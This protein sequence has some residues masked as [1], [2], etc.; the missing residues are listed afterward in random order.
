MRNYLV[1][2]EF[3]KIFRQLEVSLLFQPVIYTFM[4]F[5]HL[6]VLYI[7]YWVDKR[8]YYLF[9]SSSYFIIFGIIYSCIPLMFHY[10]LKMKDNILFVFTL[11]TL[12]LLIIST[13]IG[14]ISAT[15]L[16]LNNKYNDKFITECPFSFRENDYINLLNKLPIHRIYSF[17]N[18]A[19][20]INNQDTNNPN[21]Y[22]C[23]YYKT[24]I[25]QGIDCKSYMKEE[26]A[27]YKINS[28]AYYTFLKICDSDESYFICDLKKNPYYNLYY[29]YECPYPIYS[30]VTTI[31]G[32]ILILFD[33]FMNV[34]VWVGEYLSYCKYKETMLRL[35]SEENK[36]NK[37]TMETSKPAEEDPGSF[38]KNSTEYIFYDGNDS[39]KK[40]NIITLEKNADNG[41]IKNIK[42]EDEKDNNL[43]NKKL[44]N[45]K[46]SRTNSENKNDKNDEK[47][48]S[49][50]DKIIKFNSIGE[51]SSISPINIDDKGIFNS[52]NK[53]NVFSKNK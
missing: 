42:N 8:Y 29:D 25:Q 4:I 1:S 23:N 32:I 43:N 30:I 26:F 40:S 22:I 19:R 24:N 52:L 48:S 5:V 11:I 35:L 14:I 2:Q 28:D 9:I 27:N 39:I 53:V 6:V 36:K 12:V 38:K 17:C 41:I 34:L 37:D 13:L 7:V 47:E 44:L 10:R 50:E 33:I 45:I 16:W 49:I 3:R 20:C 21:R 51:G 18:K 46:V 15:A 31:L